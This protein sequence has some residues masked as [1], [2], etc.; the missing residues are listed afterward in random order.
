MSNF[1]LKDINPKIIGFYSA[2]TDFNN[3]QKQ[4]EKQLA[5]LREDVS[6][7][8]ENAFNKVSQL[9]SSFEFDHIY[10]SL[11]QSESILFTFS[12]LKS[13]FELKMEVYLDYN[14]DDPEDIEAILNIYENG[15]KQS[16]YF[17]TVEC[18]YEKILSLI[19]PNNYYVYGLENA[20]ISFN[21]S[22]AIPLS[23]SSNNRSRYN[24]AHS[25]L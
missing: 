6:I 1:D 20:K 12:T 5:L 14:S 23:V 13:D 19:S 10:I 17:G 24:F 9:I 7:K 8:A 15:I 16:P 22:Q 25:N 11:T 3:A 4:F 21:I 2:N 18:L